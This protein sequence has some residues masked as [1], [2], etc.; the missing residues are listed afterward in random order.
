[1]TYLMT[2]NAVAQLVIDAVGQ[3]GRPVKGLD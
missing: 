2:A 1:M 3:A